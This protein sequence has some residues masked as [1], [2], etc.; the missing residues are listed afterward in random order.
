MRRT[1]FAWLA[2]ACLIA[3]SFSAAATPSFDESEDGIVY[4]WEPA[5][6]DN[7]DSDSGHWDYIGS[8]SRFDNYLRLTQAVGGQTGV[9]WFDTP[10]DYDFSAEFDYL[11]GGGD[12]ADGMVMMF[13]K[14]MAYDPAGGGYLGFV[15][16]PMTVEGYGL[17]FDTYNNGWGDEPGARYVGL[18]EDDPINN[19]LA[20][21][22][23]DN[24]RD[25]NWHHVKL[26]VEREVDEAGVPNPEVTI[27]NVFIDD[28]ATPI[29]TWAGEVDRTFTGFGFGAGTGGSY[30]NHLIDN[31]AVSKKVAY[32]V[33]DGEVIVEY[34][35]VQGD[36][37]KIEEQQVREDGAWTMMAGNTALLAITILVVMLAANWLRH[38]KD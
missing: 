13:F 25:N 3:A 30:D 29:I 38:R 12:G 16:D 11:I 15:G 35:F 37:V 18:I 10:V 7:F 23:R 36:E 8:A 17:E 4:N 1:V 27:I 6:S 14:D 24:M 2:L 31:L 28:M 21:A 22:Y 32:L 5:F 33:D 26:V 9:A 20:T 19:H 34:I